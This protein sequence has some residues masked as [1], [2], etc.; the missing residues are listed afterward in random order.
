LDNSNNLPP[1]G[2]AEPLTLRGAVDQ[3]T[4]ERNKVQD[5]PPQAPVPAQGYEDEA[6]I[7]P[8]D[9]AAIDAEPEATPV[10]QPK[11]RLRD[12]TEATLEELEDWRKGTLRQQD[13]TKKTQELAE[14]R[15][16]FEADF[17]Q[18]QQRTQAHAS[19]IDNAI[20]IAHHFLPKPPSDELRKQDFYAWQ[21]QKA[22][23]DAQVGK[24]NTLVGQRNE[25]AA[26]EQQKHSEAL[27]QFM[28]KEQEMLHSLRPEFKDPVKAQ[29]FW[30]DAVK[31]GADVGFTPDD[32]NQM[33]STANHRG[34]L[35][36]EKAVKYD[37]IM[38]QKAK[39]AEKAKNAEPMAPPVAAPGR[40]QSPAERSGAALRPLQ[41]RLDQTGNLRDAARLLAA[42]RAARR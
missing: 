20:A 36:L 1:G 24:L 3:I 35:L 12:G 39:L 27:K 10:E 2:T 41:D 38:A 26:Q 19:A 37:R 21:E 7:D 31:T 14:Q 34:Y 25:L 6:P 42:E 30:S 18:F 29:K 17:G 5:T 16:K 8:A 23:Y 32:M 4:A 33:M 11:I 13:Y 28:V 15:K 40:R 9:L 22:E